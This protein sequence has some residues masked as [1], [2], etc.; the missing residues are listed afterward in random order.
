MAF[1]ILQKQSYTTIIRKILSLNF[2]T[3][4]L[5]DSSFPVVI[6]TVNVGEFIIVFGYGTNLIKCCI[7]D[8]LRNC[9]ITKNGGYGMY[10]ASI[11]TVLIRSIINT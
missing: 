1:L 5:N 3:I 7:C 6:G 2:C 9:F 11:F 4:L 8:G 10:S